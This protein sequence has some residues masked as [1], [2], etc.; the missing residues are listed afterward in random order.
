MVHAVKLSIL[1]DETD[2]GDKVGRVVIERQSC[3]QLVFKMLREP[4]AVLKR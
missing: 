3:G 1:F 2:G 4:V